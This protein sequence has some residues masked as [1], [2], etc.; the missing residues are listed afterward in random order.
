MARNVYWALSDAEIKWVR[1]QMAKWA[2]SAWAGAALGWA[3]KWA[4]PLWQT[5]KVIEAAPKA[6]KK[7]LNSPKIAWWASPKQSVSKGRYSLAWAWAVAQPATK[8]I[9]RK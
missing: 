5:K 2:K 3:I 9:I 6:T 4:K 1:N 7:P 8:R